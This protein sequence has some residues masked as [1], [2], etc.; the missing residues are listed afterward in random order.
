MKY[1]LLHQRSCANLF[2]L[3][4]VR[5]SSTSLHQC[6][7]KN[8]INGFMQ[9]ISFYNHK[10]LLLNI[11]NIRSLQRTY[12]TN[13]SYQSMNCQHLMHTLP[14]IPVKYLKLYQ[15]NKNIFGTSHSIS[16]R[17]VSNKSNDNATKSSVKITS[18]QGKKKSQ[19]KKRLL[20][21]N[22]VSSY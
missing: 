22:E 6:S 20:S 2:N 10:S 9:N 1:L 16:T 19:R 21:D 4:Y 13:P 5:Y 17:Y 7:T 14:N 12:F 8:V 18:L 15:T 3:S 11:K